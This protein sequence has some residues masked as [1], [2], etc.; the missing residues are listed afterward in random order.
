MLTIFKNDYVYELFLLIFIK[1]HYTI[2]VQFGID[3]VEHIIHVQV[4][5]LPLHV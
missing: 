5:F 4:M 1:V 2:G 3:E